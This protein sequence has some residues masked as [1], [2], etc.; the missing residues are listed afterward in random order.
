MRYREGWCGRD[1][2]AAF[3][4]W[5][6][7]CLL[8]SA[9][10][11]QEPRI[12]SL[13][14]RL[15]GSDQK[16]QSEAFETLIGLR[17][18]RVSSLMQIVSDKE[19]QEHDREAV[20]A[21]IGL[22]GDIRAAESVDLLVEMLPFTAHDWPGR[23]MRD[24]PSPWELAPAVEALIKIGKPAERAVMVAVSQGKLSDTSTMLA[25][26]IVRMIEGSS[27]QGMM[28][29]RAMADELGPGAGKTLLENRLF[30]SIFR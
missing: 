29:V 8:A 28:A 12:E 17:S 27:S 13:I 16:Q 7:F 3:I 6:H 14:Q 5:L 15:A 20:R 1:A 30:L 18:K 23:P 10:S 21:A 26:Y 11:A 9:A 25:G 22:L 2:A 19:R 24:L 4:T